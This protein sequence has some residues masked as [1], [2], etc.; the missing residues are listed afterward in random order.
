[1]FEFA[2]QVGNV[3]PIIVDLG[4]CLFEIVFLHHVLRLQRLQL[5]LQVAVLLLD[6]MTM[7]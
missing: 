4:V 3:L 1:M 6:H 2:F 5:I 7:R